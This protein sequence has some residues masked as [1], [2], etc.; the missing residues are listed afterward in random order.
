MTSVNSFHCFCDLT[1]LK[2]KVSHIENIQNIHIFNV[3]EKKKE[4]SPCTKDCDRAQ[5]KKKEKKN[6]DRAR[7]VV[8]V[9]ER[10]K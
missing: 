6:C 2:K 4:M 1:E 8:T 9:Y 5:K 3:R 10:K 7:K